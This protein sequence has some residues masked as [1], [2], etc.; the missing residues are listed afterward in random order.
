MNTKNTRHAVLAMGLMMMGYSSAMAVEPVGTA[1]SYQ[2]RLTLQNQLV[3]EPADLHF[4]LWDAEAGGNQIAG[5]VEL[6]NWPVNDGLFTVELDFG[7]FAF[8]G[9]GRYLEIEVRTPAGEGEFVTLA[10]RQRLSP[11]PYAIGL[12]LPYR[13][14]YAAPGNVFSIGNLGTGRALN[15]QISNANNGE[16]ALNAVTTGSGPA[17][18]FLNDGSGDA[19]NAR[20]AMG[21]GTA[22]HGESGGVGVHGIHSSRGLPTPG[23]IGETGSSAAEAIGV[24]GRVTSQSAGALSAGVRGMNAG[25][26]NLGIGVYGSQEGGGWGVY[27]TTPSGRGV[28]GHSDSGTGVYGLHQDNAGTSPGVYGLTQSIEPQSAGVS[29]RASATGSTQTY[30]VY[31][32]SMSILGVGVGGVGADGVRGLGNRYGVYGEG[33]TY[34]QVA[35]DTGIPLGSLKRYLGEGLRQLRAQFLADGEQE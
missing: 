9:E 31:G 6:D 16:A 33:R 26:R 10:P 19:I 23:V 32:E 18:Y 21:T 30:G 7:P 5:A 22:V 12:S 34:E 25:T 28:Y 20:V 24:L 8:L 1:F 11:T 27:G 4:T 13:A 35:Q 3:D 14:E 17:G 15:V 29:G 2:G